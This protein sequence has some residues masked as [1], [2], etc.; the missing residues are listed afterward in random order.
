MAKAA[1]LRAVA[2]A[3]MMA[4]LVSGCTAP[5]PP[6]PEAAPVQR[7]PQITAAGP[8][9]RSME[10]LALE[11]SF[12]RSQQMA[13]AAGRMRRDTDPAD[14]PFDAAA[15][16]RDFERIAFYSE[17]TLVGGRITERRGATTMARWERPVRIELHFGASVDASMR[18]DDTARMRAYVDR[19]RAATGH[20]IDLV[21]TGGNFQVYVADV[22]EL[23]A[24][25]PDI[26]ARVP[27]LAVEWVGE[28]TRSDPSTYCLVYTL[29]SGD[30][31]RG[32]TDAVAF[33][34]AEHPTLMR[35]ACYQEEL[36][37]GLGLVND[38]D[39]ARPSIFNDDDEFALLTRHDELLLRMLYDLRL[40][41]GMSAA[42]AR[43]IVHQIADRLTG[44]GRV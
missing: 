21:R 17:Y 41:S 4:A 1:R 19:L 3:V 13:L 37:Q 27:N 12:V 28:I 40:R 8:S 6:P 35:E 38:A 16:A 23:R 32:Y 42:E 26:S 15:L 25:G 34:R 43:P 5:P 20:P 9:M 31:S 2:G 18:A 7:P 39:E 22:D 30:P 29:P 24:L 33:I 11:R 10:S 44:G 14:A 36:A